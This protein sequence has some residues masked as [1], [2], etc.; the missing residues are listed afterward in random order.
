MF[1]QQRCR[2]SGAYGSS[3]MSCDCRLVHYPS[4]NRTRIP[5]SLI[6]LVTMAWRNPSS[7]KCRSGITPTLKEFIIKMDTQTAPLPFPAIRPGNSHTA[8]TQG[9]ILPTRITHTLLL[10][11]PRFYQVSRTSTTRIPPL[12]RGSTTIAQALFRR[13]SVCFHPRCIIIDTLPFPAFP[14]PSYPTNAFSL[15]R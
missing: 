8:K 11:T 3:E 6:T 10:L 15:R 5:P 4:V 12:A 13:W 14:E 9:I 7:T 1:L 2:P